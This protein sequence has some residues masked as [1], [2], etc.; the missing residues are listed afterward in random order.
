M[1]K[2]LAEK[3][4]N[5]LKKEKSKYVTVELLS[6]SIGL[7]PD[8]ISRDLSF[9]ASMLNFDPE[10]NL[11]ELIPAIEEYLHGTGVTKA[12]KPKKKASAPEANEDFRQYLFDHMTLPGGLFDKKTNLSDAQLKTLKKLI[13]NE[14]N[15]RKNTK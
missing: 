15:N 4:L 6:Q 12:V 1:K 7:Y 10:Y 3:Y 5:A 13:T 8:I 9:F 11:K 14:I 2:T